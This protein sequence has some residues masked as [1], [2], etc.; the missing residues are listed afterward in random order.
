MSMDNGQS[1][2]GR[3]RLGSIEITKAALAEGI[4]PK[5]PQAWKILRMGFYQAAIIGVG[6]AAVSAFVRRFWE[7]ILGGALGWIVG[8]AH[9]VKF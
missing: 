8:V 6:I 4:V 5:R 1:H 7:V 9:I 2:A 3:N